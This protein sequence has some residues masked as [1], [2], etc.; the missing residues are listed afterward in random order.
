MDDP[1]SLLED[2]LLALLVSAPIVVDHANLFS[3]GA[4][5]RC[6]TLRCQVEVA[7]YLTGDIGE[8]VN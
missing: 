4:C 7:R 5:P 1:L 2:A 3:L 6:T 8:D